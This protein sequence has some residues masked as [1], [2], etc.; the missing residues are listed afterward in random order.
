M[1]NYL[2]TIVVFAVG[3]LTGMAV[4]PPSVR[5]QATATGNVYVDE[6]GGETHQQQRRVH[7]LLAFHV[8]RTGTVL[9]TAMS[10]A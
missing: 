8:R 9:S 6:V 5:A 10:P 1:K 7:K 4:R 2:I 3:I